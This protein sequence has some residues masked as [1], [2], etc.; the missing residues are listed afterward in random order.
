MGNFPNFLTIFRILRLKFLN[1]FL[2]V[3]AL[4]MSFY[5]Q[6]EKNKLRVQ[7]MYFLHNIRYNTISRHVRDPYDPP[8]IPC[9]PHDP[10]TPKSGCRDR[11]I[12]RI[13]AS[14][15]V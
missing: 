5:A 10:S 14:D 4:K 3:I 6:N 9:G 13:D 2:L 11:P 8:T 1:T 12:P 7:S 15:T